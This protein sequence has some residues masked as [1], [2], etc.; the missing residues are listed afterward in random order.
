MSMFLSADEVRDL[1]KRVHYSAQVKVLRSMGIEHR[2]RPDGSLAVLRAH[3]EQVLG[4]TT[5]KKRKTTPAEPN[6]SALDAAR[7]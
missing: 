3:V 4:L 6:W 2:A 7:A 5:P 1:T